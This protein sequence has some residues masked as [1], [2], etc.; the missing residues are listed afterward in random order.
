MS[1]DQTDSN[2]WESS[3]QKSS[4]SQDEE[5]YTQSEHDS[6][7]PYTSSQ[8]S[9]SSIETESETS[10]AISIAPEI[11]EHSIKKPKFPKPFVSKKITKKKKRKKRKRMGYSTKK[12]NYKNKTKGNKR[13]NE[14]RINILKEELQ[15]Y[16]ICFLFGFKHSKIDSDYLEQTKILFTN[17]KKNLSKSRNALRI[18]V[19]LIFYTTY[20][21]DF[22]GNETL[23]NFTTEFQ[24]VVSKLEEILENKE[25]MKKQ[26]SLRKKKNKRSFIEIVS[27]INS[28]DWKGAK[29]RI[30]HFSNANH[31]K[32]FDL[33]DQK[34]I[35]RL[36]YKQIPYYYIICGQT[37]SKFV[38]KIARIYNK[39]RAVTCQRP[40]KRTSV[41]SKKRKKKKKGKKKEEEEEE[42]ERKNT[43]FNWVSIQDRSKIKSKL[44]KIFNVKELSWDRNKDTVKINHESLI[45][46]AT[47]LTDHKSV[48]NEWHPFIE[49][50]VKY[51]DFKKSNWEKV[52]TGESQPVYVTLK[53]QISIKKKPFASGTFRK[54]FHTTDTNNKRF[55]VK[56]FKDREG[57]PESYEQLEAECLNELKIQYISKSLAMKFNE[58]QPTHAID[59][60]AGFICTFR[61]TD[62]IKNDYF[63]QVCNAEPFL[64]GEYVK[65]CDNKFY[66]ASQTK[67]STIYS[68]SHYTYHITNEKYMVVDLQG[69]NNFLTDPAINS[70]GQNTN[71]NSADLGKL[72]ITKFFES[73][74]CNTHCKKLG[75]KKSKSSGEHKTHIA[76]TKV[77][78]KLALLCSNVFCSNTVKVHHYQY[79]INSPYYCEKCKK[80]RLQLYKI[81]PKH[82]PDKLKIIKKK[83]ISSLFKKNIFY[84]EIQIISLK[85]ECTVGIGLTNSRHSNKIE[86]K[87]SWNKQISYHSSGKF[88][89]KH[90]EGVY[91][92]PRFKEKDTIGLYIHS[93]K[94]RLYF[95]KNGKNLGTYDVSNYFFSKD[96]DIYSI[97]I[98]NDRDLQIKEKTKKQ[99]FIYNPF[100]LSKLR[101]IC[102]YICNECKRISIPECPSHGVLSIKT[103]INSGSGTDSDPDSSSSS[104]SNFDSNSDSD[105]DSNSNSDSDSDSDDYKNDKYNVIRC[106]E[107]DQSILK[108]KIIRCHCD[109]KLNQDNLRFFKISQSH[110][111]LVEKYFPKRKKIITHAFLECKICNSIY[112]TIDDLKETLKYKAGSMKH[113][114]DYLIKHYNHSPNIKWNHLNNCG[115]IDPK[116]IRVHEIIL[117]KK[118][119]KQI[120]QKIKYSPLIPI[121]N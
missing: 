58:C 70:L 89:N 112:F 95:T 46:T 85:K 35:Q 69:V 94:R 63:Y 76:Q 59:F 83:D 47:T 103:L 119:I 53:K 64:K 108:S 1:F 101:Q 9:S 57:G 99:H 71:F 60:L 42:E 27:L 24:D 33:D 48:E 29:K 51:I 80:D 73:H 52:I 104:S 97:V 61:E 67:H 54:A 32:E 13:H 15:A 41:S 16:K 2:T 77:S 90:K 120:V 66:K 92:G 84:S 40:K 43:K 45:K 55:V 111:R 72:G 30:V 100:K 113:K 79:K 11:S 91:Y 74:K 75:L 118:K 96:K 107:C 78:N 109:K 18:Y 68:F 39:G 93:K 116:N 50:E 117:E 105:S 102:V 31:S 98:S 37:P 25:E 3:E 86:K 23:V 28:L 14:E 106:F 82:K 21:Q 8:S 34:E 114:K 110:I 5:L 20:K 22:I 62:R 7:S 56:F 65:Y 26:A 49:V 38:R 121:K 17:L 115:N 10:T 36:L 87:V 12:T 88:H 81:E 44:I 6:V 4:S 19:S